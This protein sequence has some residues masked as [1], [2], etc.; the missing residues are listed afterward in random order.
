[1]S[2]ASGTNT[3]EEAMTKIHQTHSASA[4]WKGQQ[5][6]R[7]SDLREE[8]HSVTREMSHKEGQA[9]QHATEKP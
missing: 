8:S 7:P 3:V 5:G 4:Q 2:N 1:M 6:T 9:Y